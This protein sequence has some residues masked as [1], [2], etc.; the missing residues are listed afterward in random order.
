MFLKISWKDNIHLIYYIDVILPIPLPKLFTYQITEAEANF[1]KVGM[2]VAVPFGKSKILTAL[3]YRQ[4]RNAPSAYEAK[5]IYQILDEAPI[6]SAPQISLWEWLAEYYMCS[7]GEIMKASL[8]NLFLLESETI[9]YKGDTEL[10]SNSEEEEMILRMLDHQTDVK[11]NEISNL[12]EG[13][14]AMSLISKMLEKGQIKIKEE[15]FEQYK[16]K[17]EKYIKISD[18]FSSSDKLETLMVHMSRAKKQREALLFY[19]H[20]ARQVDF[21]KKSQFEKEGNVSASTIKSLVDKGIFEIYS[22]EIDRILLEN[23]NEGL[24]DL[25]DAQKVALNEIIENFDKEKIVLLHGITSSGK[26]EIYSKLIEDQLKLG[27]QVLYL[28]PE[29]ALTTQIINRLQKY[30]A[31]QMVVFHSKYS[32]QERVESWNKILN[33]KNE[34]QIILGARSSLLLPLNNLGLIIIDEEH[35]HSYKQIDPAPRY[36]ARDSAIVLGNIQKSNILLGS[37]TPSLESYHNTK[38]GKYALVELNSRFGDVLLPDIEL[39]DIKDKHKRKRMT[40]H[41]S[42]R[43]IE[44]IQESLSKQEQVILFQNRRGFAPV[45]ECETCGFSPNCIHC[46]VTLTFHKYNNELRC[47]Y[48]GHREVLPLACP[49][50]GNAHL[51]TKGFGTEQIEIELKSLF[52]EIKI[53]RMDYD[54]TRTKHG[55]QK[56]IEAFENREVDILV[57]TQMLS[58]GLDFKHVSL[59]GILNADNMLNFPDFRAHERSF[60]LMTQVAGRA[61]RSENKGQV[62]IQTYNPYHQILQQVSTNDYGAMYKDQIYERQQFKYPPIV[63][64]VKI[65]LKHKN[66]FL[67]EKASDWL[68]KSLTNQFGS[69]VLGPASPS[70]SKIR[71]LYI[72]NVLIKIEKRTALKESKELIQKIKL[73]FESI[74]EFRSIRFNID[75]DPY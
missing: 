46:D 59:V 24:S 33:H 21:L 25:T 73:S 27:K 68:G 32:N 62:I 49:A 55:Y 16:P 50:C 67:L 19:F 45:V 38:V 51:N 69:A 37:A 58:K 60:Q 3:A 2:R 29:I 53:A 34:G 5:E 63:R 4:H 43:L 14:N 1:L 30:F 71:N 6:I 28:L 70:I 64:L 26:T 54:T 47:H 44:A 23:S 75:V 36:H 57:G 20:K 48:C 10:E 18:E 15:I 39:T 8:P 17:L 52:P 66:N 35:E 42:D 13:K 31:D 7:L 56:I 11:V 61:G 22:K 9:V 12:I 65:T 40:G 74:A 72:K 41:F